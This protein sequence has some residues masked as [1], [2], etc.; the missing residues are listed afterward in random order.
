MQKVVIFTD[1]A[2]KGNPGRGGIGFYL[3]SE[4]GKTL[5]GSK[6]YRRTTSSRMELMAA[7]EALRC[8][9]FPCKV[10]LY[11]DSRYLADSV[12]KGW[13]NS[14]LSSPYFLNR[15]NEDLW[16][17]LVCEMRKHQVSIHWIKGHSDHA[18]N[19]LVDRLASKA[20]S[21]SRCLVD[22]GYVY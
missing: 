16:R 11:T 22:P 21:S 15:K 7:I 6:G 14:W 2:C 20:C 3:I 9:K 13:L 5:K 8:L 17:K 1:G 10:E 4:A 18:Q 19:R 12:N